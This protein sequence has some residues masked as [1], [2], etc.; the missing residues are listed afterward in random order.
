[1][2]V[3][4]YLES[5]EAVE[6]M[7]IAIR[8]QGFTKERVFLLPYVD[9]AKDELIED[10]ALNAAILDAQD[11]EEIVTVLSI[12]DKLFDE[13]FK[14]AATSVHIELQEAEEEEEYYA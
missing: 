8:E 2:D 9:G 12:N 13:L 4:E 3:M 6:A 7:A 1:M 11:G 10:M 5:E 14:K